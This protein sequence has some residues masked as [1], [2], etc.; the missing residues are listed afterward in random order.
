[1]ANDILKVGTYW[2]SSRKYDINLD[3]SGNVLI[4][5]PYIDP[6]VEMAGYMIK[7]DDVPKFVRSLKEVRTYYAIYTWRYN[8]E[9]PK[10]IDHDIE[11]EM[12]AL[13]VLWLRNGKMHFGNISGKCWF[14]YY[15]TPDRRAFISLY[16]GEA[17]SVYDY[18]ER[19]SPPACIIFSSEYELQS[20]IEGLTPETLRERYNKA[21]G[22]KSGN[23]R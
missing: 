7:K 23:K 22:E 15:Y 21:K 14:L 3:A 6:T 18:R 20:L 1:M 10:E 13:H 16:S 5:S 9:K 2:A 4:E 8:C 12:P 17:I 11:V 19:Y